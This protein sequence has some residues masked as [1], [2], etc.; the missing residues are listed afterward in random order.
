MATP[1][2]VAVAVRPSSAGRAPEEPGSFNPSG[3][4][5]LTLVAPGKVPEFKTDEDG[6]AE[7]VPANATDVS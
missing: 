3:N 4:A 1:R 7:A 2:P 6:W 5:Y